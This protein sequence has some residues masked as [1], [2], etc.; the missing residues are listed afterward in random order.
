MHY[1]SRWSAFCVALLVVLGCLPLGG[2]C[3][4]DDPSVKVYTPD[5][6]G[7]AECVADHPD[8]ASQCSQSL[9]GAEKEH[10]A[11]A[12]TYT[13]DQCMDRYGNNACVQRGD[14]YVPAIAGFML[15]A[16]VGSSMHYQPIYVDRW[17]SAY[18]GTV[19]LGSFRPGA[20][21]YITPAPNS[22]WVTTYRYTTVSIPRNTP[23]A[24]PAFTA[25]SAPGQAPKIQRGGTGAGAAIATVAPPTT[26]PPAA[27]GP[28]PG[29]IQRGNTGTGAATTAS[30]PP[31][32]DRK[33]PGE[34]PPPGGI[35]RGNTGASAAATSA[36]PP[37]PNDTKAVIPPSG[38]QRGNTG[39]S[40]APS[41]AMPPSGPP[42]TRPRDDDH[43][44]GS[45]ARGNMGGSPPTRAS[46]P[47]YQPSSG[48]GSSSRSSTS[49]GKGR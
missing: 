43:E 44:H 37:K 8:Q 21:L 28:A 30:A 31:T 6:Q 40:A 24:A 45:I 12:E 34:T 14:H 17:G 18:S 27:L 42:Q 48:S 5:E 38:I 3:S 11:T 46:T 47:S 7:V 20:H 23:S 39:G 19:V 26:K 41:G 49:S 2:G 15:G 36:A 16:M 4:S 35:Q 13:Y 32:N 22:T 10:E 33:M 9:Q 29:S 1:K 25:P